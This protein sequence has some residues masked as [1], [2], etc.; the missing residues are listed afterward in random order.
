MNENNRGL[1]QS[2]ERWASSSPD[3]VALQFE[4]EPITYGELNLRAN[5]VANGLQ[6]VGVA[7]GDRVAIML[8]NIPEFVYTLVG[9]L[10]LGAVAVPFNTLYKGGEILHILKDSGAKVLVALTNFAPMINEVR[11]E[12]PDLEQV[13]LTGERNLVFGHPQSTAFIQLILPGDLVDDID[14]AYNKIGHVLLEI[15]RDLGVKE[16]WYKHRGSIRV[17]GDKIATFV[18]SEVEGIALVNALTFLAPLDTRDFLRI[19][20]VPPEVRDKV[21]EPLTSVEQET[22][23]RPPWDQVKETAIGAFEKAFEV[24]LKESPMVRDELFGYEKLRS[25]AYKTR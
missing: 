4:G 9:T 19:V 17:R 2:I 15:V 16:A 12:L 7:K 24:E 6:G 10:K 20:W 1:V 18:I 14:G 21:V 11:P 8:P 23:K 25:L 13:I 3:S 22:G 5:R